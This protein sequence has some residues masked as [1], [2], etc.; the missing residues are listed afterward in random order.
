MLALVFIYASASYSAEKAGEVLA[1]KKHVYV[2]RDDNR[3]SAEPQMQLLMKDVVETD[4]ESRTKLFFTD[5]SILNLGELSRVEVEEYLY[6]SEQN[7]SK[8]IY[9]LI[10]GSLRVVVG[11]SDL[12]VHTATAVAAARGSIFLVWKGNSYVRR[13]ITE[14]ALI[15]RT[16][17]KNDKSNQTCVMTIE[18]KV[19]LML[20]KEAVT[21]DTKKDRVMVNEGTISCIN[22]NNVNPTRK[23]DFGDSHKWYVAGGFP[24]TGKLA[25]AGDNCA[26]LSRPAKRKNPPAGQFAGDVF[27]I[28]KPF[29]MCDP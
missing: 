11:R 14:P 13:K 3:N 7:R 28:P 23:A 6:N 16:A 15:L 1:V 4:T 18:G 5:N 27:I 2:V 17:G 10:D 8:S 19:E 21:K 26:G 20:K 25:A 22:G 29:V 24:V 9:K 12:E